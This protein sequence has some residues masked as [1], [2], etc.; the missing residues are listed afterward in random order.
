MVEV[1]RNRA[2]WMSW[3]S[4]CHAAVDRSRWR[5]DVQALCASPAQRELRLKWFSMSIKLI[6]ANKNNNILHLM[7][8]LT[9]KINRTDSRPSQMPYWVM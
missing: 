3:K 1:E 9:L 8:F 2:D 4:E 7:R 5:R 6:V